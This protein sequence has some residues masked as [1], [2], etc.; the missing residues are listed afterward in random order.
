MHEYDSDSFPHSLRFG[1]ARLVFKHIFAKKKTHQSES[2]LF[3]TL[4][5]SLIKLPIDYSICVNSKLQVASSRQLE[6]NAC[7]EFVG[8]FPDESPYLY[9]E[10]ETSI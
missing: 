2:R 1:P 5:S 8:F 6:F 3:E 9:L 10:A 7:S 4:E